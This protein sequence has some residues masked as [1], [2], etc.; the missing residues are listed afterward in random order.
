MTGLLPDVL[1]SDIATAGD[2]HQPE[3]E[4]RPSIR[5]SSDAEFTAA[6]G[7]RSGN[8]L[9]DDPYVIDRWH[10]VPAVGAAVTI[11]GTSA[12]VLLRG[13]MVDQPVPAA[14][15]WVCWLWCAEHQVAPPSRVGILVEQSS[16]VTL[17]ANVVNGFLNAV[18]VANAR[19]VAIT[20]NHLVYND[21]TAEAVKLYRSVQDMMEQPPSPP[22]T[23]SIVPIEPASVVLRAFYSQ[24]LKVEGNV[25]AGAEI[26][27]NLFAV[28]GTFSGNV[29][30]HNAVAFRVDGGSQLEFRQNFVIENGRGWSVCGGGTTVKIEFNQISLNR[31]EVSGEG[32]VVDEN[33]PYCTPGETWVHVVENVIEANLMGVRFIGHGSVAGNIIAGNDVGVY[34]QKYAVTIEANTVSGS[35]V[36]AILRD[37][38]EDSTRTDVRRNCFRENGIGAYVL[39]VEKPVF[40]ENGF[41]HNA[42][43]ALLNTDALQFGS[44]PPPGEI[45]VDARF[46]WWGDAESSSLTYGAVD[47]VPGLF[48]DPGLC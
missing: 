9:S 35:A 16:N 31:G 47:L 44:S 42:N 22:G 19:D 13:N 27:A 25:M 14:R 29:V 8:G 36:G 32:V 5:I 28:G 37:I 23:P 12:H 30:T 40:R 3:S 33:D 48:A 11:R 15:A 6:N 45:T 26:G 24:G 34:Q 43:Y 10:I 17:A 18:S 1:R 20:G 41:V 21:T 38:S 46:N 7:V 39:G 2:S 4:S